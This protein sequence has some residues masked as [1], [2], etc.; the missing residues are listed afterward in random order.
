VALLLL[1][2]FAVLLQLCTTTPLSLLP[3][4][5]RGHM[6]CSMLIFVATRQLSPLTCNLNIKKRDF[7]CAAAA[8]A[9][10]LPLRHHAVA[11]AAVHNS[12]T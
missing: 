1:L 2:S 9:I 7:A 3:P 12:T 5:L 6:K 4:H 8:A 10:L 11:A